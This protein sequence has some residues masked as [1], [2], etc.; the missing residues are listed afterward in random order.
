MK[1]Y[2][3]TDLL[4]ISYNNVYMYSS[5]YIKKPSNIFKIPSF[6]IKLDKQT[7]DLNH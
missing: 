2:N 5:W 6:P 3:K 7:F 1:F 4:K